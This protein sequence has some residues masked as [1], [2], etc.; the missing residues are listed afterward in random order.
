M[1]GVSSLGLFVK[2]ER[3]KAKNGNNVEFGVWGLGNEKLEGQATILLG[4]KYN[5][6]VAY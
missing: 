4:L 2:N 3:M 6:S 5:S 1:R